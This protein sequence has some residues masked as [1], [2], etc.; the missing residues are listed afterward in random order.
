MTTVQ[1]WHCEPP[2]LRRYLDGATDLVLSA[3]VEAHLIGCAGCREVLAGLADPV[4]LQRAWG[5]VL[6][7]VQRPPL[8]LPLRVLR[9]LGLSERDAVLLSAS[10]SLRGP[11]AFATAVLLIFAA[12]ASMPDVYLGRTFYLTVAPLVPV[13]GVVGAFTPTELTVVTPYSKVRLALLRTAA[14]IV[15][16]VPFIVAFGGI[17]TDI[18]WLAVAWMGPGLGL[19]LTALVL[20]TWWPPMRTGAVLTGVWLAVVIAYGRH[21]VLVTVRPPAQLAYLALACITAVALY[22]RIRL[23]RTPGGYA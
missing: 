5:G 16:T 4:P 2:L 13:L 20:L 23:N 17:V 18:G 9:R 22:I 7:A 14:V 19:T 1:G 8:P 21:D 10:Q 11:W 12:V 15:T 6:E 3:S